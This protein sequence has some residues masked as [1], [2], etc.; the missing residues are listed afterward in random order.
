MHFSRAALLGAAAGMAATAAAG[1]AA[2]AEACHVGPPDHVRG[3]LVFLN[4]DQA[5][6]DAAYDQSAYAPLA[7]QIQARIRANAEAARVRL[8]EPLRVAYGPTAIEKLDIYR[9]HR[10]H[11]PIFVF[12]HGGAWKGKSAFNAGAY[13]ESLVAHGATFI[14]P[15]FVAVDDAGGDL[16]V[17]ADQVRRAV[18]WIWKNAATFGGDRDRLYV[19]GHSSGG[20]LSGVV[21]VTDWTAYGLPPAPLKGGMCMSGMYELAPVALSKRNAYV[22]FTPATLEALSSQRHID[23]IHAPLVV[24]YGTFETPEFQRQNREF[25]AAVKAAGKPVQLVVGTGYNHYEMEESL[26]NPY[27]PNGRAA[28]TLMGLTS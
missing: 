19:G 22:N 15:D 27:A 5:E 18:A 21:H 1:P 11:A 3:P 13:A 26:G 2:A 14:A 23:R 28:L 4:Y 9:T 6:L 24:S 20:H 16:N 8:G 12:I 25:A 17:M 7:A 10:P